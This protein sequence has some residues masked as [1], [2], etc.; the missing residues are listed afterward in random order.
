MRAWKKLIDELRNFRQARPSGRSIWPEAKAIREMM[1][2]GGE[3]S[4]ESSPHHKFPRAAFGLPIIF[5]F[6]DGYPED[7]GGPHCQDSL[8]PKLR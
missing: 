5:H 3:Q 1:R 7:Y 8:R 2:R 6:K 4:E